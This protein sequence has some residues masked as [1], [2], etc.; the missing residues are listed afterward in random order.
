[1]RK[2]LK[3]LALAILLAGCGTIA[4]TLPP[5]TEAPTGVHNDGRV[6]WRDLLTTTP[7]ASRQFYGELFGWSFERPP[8]QIGFGGDDDYMLIRHNGELIGGMVDANVLRSDIDISQWVTMLSVGDIDAAVAAAVAGGATVLTEPTDVGKRGTLAVLEGSAG[9]LFAVVQTRDGDPPETEPPVNGFLW[10][11]LWTQDVASSSKFYTSVFG[12]ERKDHAIEASGNTY[13][14]FRNNDRP[15]VGL[16]GHPF[17]DERSVWVNY[18]RV[19]DP[20]AVTA[21]VAELGGKV[22]LDAQPRELGGEVALV[23]GPSGA[24]IA[25]QSWSFE[26]E[27]EE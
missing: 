17:S 20:A 3:L 5:V 16:M 23:L 7:E 12:F 15:R 22:L 25:L 27:G 14:V 13:T 10:D 21:R 24:G 9:E 8:F 11:E 2:N 26:Q 4:V 19:E 6:V 18:I 1:M